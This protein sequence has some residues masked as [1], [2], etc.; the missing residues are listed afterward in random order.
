MLL[1]II[2]LVA[3]A[4]IIYKNRGKVSSPSYSEYITV[5]ESKKENM[6][7]E[8]E[9]EALSKVVEEIIHD[10]YMRNRGNTCKRIANVLQIKSCNL[11]YKTLSGSKKIETRNLLVT[12]KPM[13]LIGF[14]KIEQDG[15]VEFKATANVDLKNEE[16]LNYLNTGDRHGVMIGKASSELIKNN[17]D[18]NIQELIKTLEKR[19]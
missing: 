19:C 15:T 12:S 7:R 6:T 1:I 13:I 11:T 3:I 2:I 8:E 4:V 16:E 10:G 14:S 5:N 17:P 9:F 18:I